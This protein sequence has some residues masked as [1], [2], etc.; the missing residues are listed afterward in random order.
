[1]TG[2]MS[3]VVWRRYDSYAFIKDDEELRDY[4]CIPSGLQQTSP[5]GW[6]AIQE[7]AK[8][9]FTGIEHPKGLRA[10]EVRVVPQ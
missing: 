2:Q 10:I 3:G 1:M 4:F 9:V 7:G 5:E 6:E 8:V